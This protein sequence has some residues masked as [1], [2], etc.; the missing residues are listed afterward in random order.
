[1]LFKGGRRKQNPKA[2]ID[3]KKHYQEKNKVIGLDSLFCKKKS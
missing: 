1:M 2:V 3:I